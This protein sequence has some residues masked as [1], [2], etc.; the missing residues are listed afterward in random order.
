MSSVI[1]VYN[2]RQQTISVKNDTPP[3][4]LQETVIE[5]NGVF[6]P[7]DGYVGFSK[8]TVNVPSVD[9]LI[10][11]SITEVTSNVETIRS[12]AFQGSTDLT[13]ANFPLVTN[14]GMYAFYGCRALTN[15]NF[16]KVTAI[17][18]YGFYYCSTLISITREN[19][20]LLTKIG[21]N[22]FERCFQ[23]KIGY[24]PK[25]TTI[26][27]SAFSSCYSLIKLI[28]G[29]E[30]TTVVSLVNTNAFQKCHHIKG[31]V[32]STYNPEGL[33]DGYIYVP[34]NLVGNYRTATN[35]VTY[36]SQIMPWVETID[37]LASIDGTLY[38]HACVGETEYVYNGVGWVEFIRGEV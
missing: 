15:I 6:M 22:V 3:P 26:G 35:W 4:T 33:N 11:G 38:D 16:P 28:I 2:E 17:D 24:F 19:L 37:E 32:N 29:T 23:L 25:A 34:S 31:T 21:A 12:R 5:S 27:A 10:D 30:T 1:K 14:I 7:E 20:P 13:T 9:S 8:V 18:N 36:A